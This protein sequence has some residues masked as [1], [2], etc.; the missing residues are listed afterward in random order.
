MLP[1]QTV[2]GPSICSYPNS[3]LFIHAKLR[4]RDTK[5]LAGLSRVS[6]L[7][8]L[9]TWHCRLSPSL[10]LF[11]SP[12][13]QSYLNPYPLPKRKCFNLYVRVLD[14]FFWSLFPRGL[15]LDCG[16]Q[17]ANFLTTKGASF[18]VNWNVPQFPKC[19]PLLSL[20]AAL[21]RLSLG[22]SSDKPAPRP[23][24]AALFVAHDCLL[25]R[26]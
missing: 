21:Q 7:Y 9:S 18:L 14:S 13:C 3:I 12:F 17:V 8:T 15:C 24:S 4:E 23:G 19:G 10:M 2:W 22:C 25:V 20:S 5:S 11:G 16:S 6:F 1:C 26:H